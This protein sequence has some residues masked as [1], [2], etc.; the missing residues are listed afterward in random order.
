MNKNQFFI[1]IIYTTHIMNDNVKFPKIIHQIWMQGYNSVPQKFIKNIEKNKA[2]NKNFAYEFWD[3]ERIL[4]LLK[5]LNNNAYI[6]TYYSYT[7]L[8][9]R[10]DFARYIIL[11]TYGGISIDMDAFVI[12]NLDALYNMIETNVDVVFSKFNMTDIESYALNGNSTHINNANI[13]SKPKNDVMHDLLEAL[14]EQSLQPK[15]YTEQINIINNTTGPIFIT[16]FLFK[17]PQ[18]DKIMYL[19]YQYLEP[20]R[21]DKCNITHNTYI[22]HRHDQS[23]IP[24]G[25]VMA[26][27]YDNNYLCGIVFAIFLI[28]I[29][30]L[31]SYYPLCLCKG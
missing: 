10:V 17:Y 8:V 11:Y 26:L 24:F 5:S 13:I 27:V 7:Y 19:D 12:K 15:K 20:C 31:W 4:N 22:V 21:D 23:W 3:E 30:V 16:N 18:Q 9:Q 28:I 6:K 14:V 25:S 1:M 29:Y 2:I